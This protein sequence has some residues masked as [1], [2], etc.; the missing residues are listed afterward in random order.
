MIITE[1]CSPTCKTKVK[2]TMQAILEKK[3]VY[4]KPCRRK[5]HETSKVAIANL[6]PLKK[7]QKEYSQVYNETVAKLGYIP[8]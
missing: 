1:C 4:C 2:T 3:I 5:V 8:S 6:P 7:K